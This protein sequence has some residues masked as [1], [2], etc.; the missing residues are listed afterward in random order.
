M[1]ASGAFAGLHTVKEIREARD[2]MAFHSA[3]RWMPSAMPVP[4][5]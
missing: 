5:P 2:A 1:G 4:R 3:R